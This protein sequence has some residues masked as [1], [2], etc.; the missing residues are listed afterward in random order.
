MTAPPRAGDE[1]RKQAFP[2]PFQ[3]RGKWNSLMVGRNRKVVHVTRQLYPMQSQIWIS[4]EDNGAEQITA[5]TTDRGIG[6]LLCAAEGK[7]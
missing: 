2:G 7:K 1:Q 3:G 4:L 6:S 5:S